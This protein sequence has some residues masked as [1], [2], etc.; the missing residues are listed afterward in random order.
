[1]KGSI[2]VSMTCKDVGINMVL[3]INHNSGAWTTDDHY[4]AGGANRAIDV[5]KCASG[6]G[7]I[8]DAKE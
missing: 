1:M 6:I 8:T 4:V 7:T 5:L 2:I 3:G